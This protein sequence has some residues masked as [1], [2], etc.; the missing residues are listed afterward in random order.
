M[1]K[2]RSKATAIEWREITTADCGIRIDNWLA[3]TLKG[4][5]KSHLYQ[6]LRTGQVRV[7]G[8]R[9][10]PDVRLAAGDAVRLPPVRVAH[11]A[12][13]RRPVAPGKTLPVVYEDDALIALNKAAGQAVHGGSGVAFGV[14]EQLR[15][16]RPQAKMLELIHRLDRETSGLLLVAKKRSALRALHAAWRE[17]K[18]EKRYL[19]LVQ[20]AWPHAAARSIRAPLVRYLLPNGERRVRVGAEGKAAHSVVRCQQVFASGFS[21]LEVEL[22]TG[23]THQI[24]VHL[25]H[26]GFPLCGDDKYGDFE[27]N[28]ILQKNG[29]RRMFLHASKL[30]F[31]HPASQQRLSLQAPLADELQAFLRR[32][33]NPAAL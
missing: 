19:A 33:E 30:V 28:K 13:T 25:A 2:P 18:V 15:S 5:P 3:K 7:N 27:S 20:G 24:R 9:A 4:V 1:N 16:Q 12:S 17:D 8:A 21:L 32:L 22:K 11:R 29:L 10:K 26:L 23:R 6:L 31:T 14:I